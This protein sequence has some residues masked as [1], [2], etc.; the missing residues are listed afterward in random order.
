MKTDRIKSIDKEV[1]QTAPTGKIVDD[2]QFF[3]L[4]KYVT[5]EEL[6]K[7]YESRGLEPA[8]IDCLNNFDSKYR[9]VLDEK[10]YVATHWKD[11]NGKWCYATFNRWFGKPMVNV[12]RNDDGWFD[13]WWFASVRKTDSNKSDTQ[14]SSETLNLDLAIETVKKAGYIIYKQM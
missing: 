14:P 13:D 3:T 1:L 2:I 10:K 4:G 7:E 5:D 9:N 12:Y 8:T 11:A 6:D